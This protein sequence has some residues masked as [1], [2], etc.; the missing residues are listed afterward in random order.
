MP[1]PGAKVTEILPRGGIRADINPRTV[2]F[3][4][5]VYAD[6]VSFT[7]NSIMPRPGDLASN[8]SAIYSESGKTYGGCRYWYTQGATVGGRTVVAALADTSSRVGLFVNDTAAPTANTFT[9]V[10]SATTRFNTAGRVEFARFGDPPKLVAM[11]G[12]EPAL[13]WNGTTLRKLDIIDQPGT[14]PDGVELDESIQT[15]TDTTNMST[16]DTTNLPVIVT[17]PATASPAGGDCVQIK[18]VGT[19][20]NADCIWTYYSTG[21]FTYM[22]GS[23]FQFYVQKLNAGTQVFSVQPVL[24]SVTGTTAPNI[25]GDPPAHVWYGPWF[26]ITTMANTWEVAHFAGPTEFIAGPLDQM[27]GRESHHSSLHEHLIYWIGWR[28]KVT[29][30]NNTAAVDIDG[31]SYGA[32]GP[33]EPGPLVGGWNIQYRV[34]YRDSLTGRTS[35]PSDPSNIVTTGTTA[36]PVKVTIVCSTDDDVDKIDV[37]RKRTGATGEIVDDTY[38]LVGTITDTGTTATFQDAPQ[39]PGTY[40][41]DEDQAAWPGLDPATT[42]DTAQVPFGV[43]YQNRLVVARMDTSEICVSDLQNLGRMPAAPTVGMEDTTG[44]RFFVGGGSTGPVT[45]MLAQHDCLYL[46]TESAFYRLTGDGFDNF[47]VELIDAGNGCLARRSVVKCESWIVWLNQY[48]Q[49][50]AYGPAIGMQVGRAPTSEHPMSGM[51]IT[52]LGQPVNKLLEAA[53]DAGLRNAAGAYWDR[54]YILSVT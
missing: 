34:V 38:R 28:V 11:N 24:A 44:G 46:W 6:D 31:L 3:G 7:A 27:F 29:T 5:A 47:I 53:D 33:V 50:V 19:G 40:A 37:Y 23:Q 52:Q 16:S 1:I 9:E 54:R 49:I 4:E 14:P 15:F 48:H 10:T 42:S 35:K 2:P 39:T 45:A 26:A 32:G 36:Y 17:T 12:Y 30:A 51:V 8:A 21:A 22:D 20:A 41:I 18:P 43:Q 13:W 25:S